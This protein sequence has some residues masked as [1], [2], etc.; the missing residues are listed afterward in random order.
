MAD[1]DRVFWKPQSPE[2][3][4]ETMFGT[5]L[6]VRRN[7]ETGLFEFQASLG[8]IEVTAFA[9]EH[10]RLAKTFEIHAGLNELTMEAERSIGVEL[11]LKDGSTV[12]PWSWDWHVN[13]E[14]IDGGRAES[15]GTSRSRGPEVRFTVGSPGL[16]RITIPDIDGYLPVRPLEVQFAPGP[17]PTI[18]V[19]LIRAH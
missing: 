1:I 6:D 8:E 10:E 13:P 19:Q 2:S 18:E 9:N 14:R 12:V 7:S 15:F 16:Y 5:I 11:V 17:H 3:N 4:G